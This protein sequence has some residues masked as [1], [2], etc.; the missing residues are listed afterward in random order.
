MTPPGRFLS[1]FHR[2]LRQLHT[3]MQY[4]RACGRDVTIS[5]SR[6]CGMAYRRLVRLHGPERPAKGGELWSPEG[7]HFCGAP[8][9]EDAKL[10][11]ITLRAVGKAK[12]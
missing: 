9:V 11:R 10:H 4:E 1:D 7:W 3:S 12:P 2:M 5:M 8:M 6:L